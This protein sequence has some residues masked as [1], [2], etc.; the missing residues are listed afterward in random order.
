MLPANVRFVPNLQLSTACIAKHIN[1]CASPF[2]ATP[3][4]VLQQ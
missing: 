4:N 1:I 2:L 3:I